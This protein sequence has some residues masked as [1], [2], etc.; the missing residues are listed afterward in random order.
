MKMVGVGSTNPVK[1]MA[2]EKAIADKLP[3]VRVVG[4]EVPSKV[5]HQ[6]MSDAETKN[7]AYERAVGVLVKLKADV[8]VG[9]EGGVMMKDGQM[10]NTVWC[11]LTDR[12]GRVAWANGLRFILPEKISREIL[13]GREMGPVMDELTGIDGVRRK[14]GMLGIVTDG[15]VDREGG[16][17]Q[18]VRLAMGRLLSEWR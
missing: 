16:Y 3:H 7:G 6:P 12:V 17:R 11:C 14:M 4:K 13:K 18:L 1:V 15:W 8:G 2:V 10:W 9:L 5:S